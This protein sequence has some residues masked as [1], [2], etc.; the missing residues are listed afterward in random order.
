MLPTNVS[1]VAPRTTVNLLTVLKIDVPNLSNFGMGQSKSKRVK[2]IM[3]C[4]FVAQR[5]DQMLSPST[6]P[7][8]RYNLLH[9]YHHCI[10]VSVDLR[11]SLSQAPYLTAFDQL[12]YFLQSQVAAQRIADRSRLW[13]QVA[14]ILT[15][16]QANNNRFGKTCGFPTLFV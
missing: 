1:F 2:R 12:S 11:D 5:E 16:I 3:R 4:L 9:Y 8:M 10:H 13:C 15:F 7:L 14:P 6:I